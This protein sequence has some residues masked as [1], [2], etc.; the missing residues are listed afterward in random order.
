MSL[1]RMGQD[2]VSS[3]QQN[4]YE[5]YIRSFLN[6]ANIPSRTDIDLIQE[7]LNQLNEQLDS[8]LNPPNHDN[9]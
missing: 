8:I 7:Q 5:D 3:M 1:V 4:I 6:E 9:E 2:R